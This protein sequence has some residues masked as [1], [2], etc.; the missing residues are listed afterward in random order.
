M[1]DGTPQPVVAILG[2][3]RITLVG[4]VPSQS[5][6]GAVAELATATSAFSD[7]PIDNQ[8]TI[9]PGVP[10]D[11]AVRLVELQSSWF[12]ESS[13]HVTPDRAV[14]LDRVVDVLNASPHLTL[15]VVGHAD[16]RG[17]DEA[18][19]QLSRRRAEAVVAYIV[20]GGIDGGRLSASGRGE[21]D[22]LSNDDDAASLTVNRRLEFV[23][24]G[25]F[26]QPPTVVTTAASA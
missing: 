24:L 19:L 23:F 5:A 25:L 13:D 22:L 4:A 6:A 8:L 17:A 11:L 14:Q 20:N 9:N 7:L 18:N 3:D 26:T 12:A 2:D 1:P 16:Q 15:A 10:L 21:A